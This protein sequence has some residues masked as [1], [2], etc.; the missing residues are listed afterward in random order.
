MKE[1]DQSEKSAEKIEL[2]C[3]KKPE[4]IKINDDD[5]RLMRKGRKH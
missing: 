4:E 3:S 5:W 1:K 2:H